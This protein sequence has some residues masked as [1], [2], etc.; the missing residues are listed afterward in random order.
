MAVPSSLKG[1][2]ALGRRGFGVLKG[3]ANAVRFVA[4]CDNHETTSNRVATLRPPLMRIR[5]FRLGG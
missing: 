4:N 3:I 2:A 5:I 1:K